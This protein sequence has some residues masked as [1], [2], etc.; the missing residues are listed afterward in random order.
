MRRTR[1]QWRRIL[2]AYEGSGESQAAFARSRGLKVG[3]LRYQLW[4]ARQADSTRADGGGRFVE[5]VSTSSGSEA[6]AEIGAAG[7]SVVRLGTAGVVEVRF[8]A[9]PPVAW[10]CAVTRGLS[11]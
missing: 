7:P 2:A 1:E 10:L 3:T 5:C 9:A 4:M 8:G 6:E 11:S